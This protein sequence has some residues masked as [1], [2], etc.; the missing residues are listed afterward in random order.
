MSFLRLCGVGGS[1]PTIGK[2]FCNV[3]LFL[4]PHSCTRSV[5]IKSS[6]TIYRCNRCIETE[7]DN[8]KSRK[9]KRLKECTLALIHAK[10]PRAKKNC[11]Y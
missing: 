7:K 3:H 9:V 5:Q 11:M 1:N 2:I 4:V 10:L 8:F 6:M